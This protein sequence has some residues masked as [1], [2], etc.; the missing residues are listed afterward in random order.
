MS[1]WRGWKPLRGEER[2]GRRWG[3]RRTVDELHRAGHQPDAFNEQSAAPN[4]SH[5]IAYTHTHTLMQETY[6][7]L[8]YSAASRHPALST[9]SRSNKQLTVT[10]IQMSRSPLLLLLLFS[11]AVTSCFSS[12][13]FLRFPL[14]EGNTW[15]ITQQTHCADTARDSPIK[16]YYLQ[17]ALRPKCGPDAHTNTAVCVCVL[18][19]WRGNCV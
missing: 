13:P 3:T 17:T 8:P 7:F 4:T 2:G 16:T 19:V 1:W 18:C 12:P 14:A 10:S 11:P 15:A 9:P 5:L 6:F